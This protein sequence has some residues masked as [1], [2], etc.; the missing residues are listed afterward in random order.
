MTVSAW[1]EYVRTDQGRQA[2]FHFDVEGGV[3]VGIEEQYFP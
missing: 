1:L 3:V 2:M